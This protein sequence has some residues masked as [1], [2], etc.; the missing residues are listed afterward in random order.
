MGIYNFDI[1]NKTMWILDRIK[2]LNDA[3]T[4]AEYLIKVDPFNIGNNELKI[5]IGQWK[6][7]IKECEEMVKDDRFKTCSKCKERK[8]KSDFNTDPSKLD[9]LHCNCK[10]CRKKARERR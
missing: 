9:G 2:S 4:K 8:Y 5:K 3:I 1:M 6:V 10:E 7:E